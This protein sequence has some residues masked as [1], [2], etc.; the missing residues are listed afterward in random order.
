MLHWIVL[1]TSWNILSGYTGYFSFGHGAFFGA[2]LYTTSTLLARYDWP[3]L[4]TL[5]VAAAVA[6]VLGRGAR[7]GGLSRPE[8]ARRAVRAAHAGDHLRSR[9]DRRQHADRR[10]PGRVARRGSGAADR[11]DA[12][13]DLL[14]ARARRGDAHA[15]RRLGDLRLALRR[16]P[17]RD[18]RRRGR[19]RGDGRAD[20]PLQARCARDLVRA[21]RRGRR[22]PCAVPVVRDGRRGVHDH[23]A[24][25]GRADERAR[26]HAPLGRPG[27]RRGRDHR[28]ALQLHRRRPRGRRQGRDR[29]D[30]DRRDPVHA[31]RHPAAPAAARCG[32]ARQRARRS[33]RQRHRHRR[34]AA[35]DAQDATRETP[36][37]EVVCCACTG[38]H[39][40]FKGVRALAGV[41]VEVRRGE[42][43]GLL[44]PNGSG[45]STFINVV[46]GHYAPT[47]RRDRL[48]RP[49]ARAAAPRIASLPPASRARTR[50]RARL[51]T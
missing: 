26:R 9:H 10:R 38:L 13:V 19:R 3:F 23:G 15:A 27:D 4:W 1:A 45:K 32:A 5:P 8:R 22:H 14:P 2:G 46:S 29:R 7:R 18:P 47:A 51:R 43:L 12:I 39:K 17:V 28:P 34:A 31:R 25:D 20:L 30:P 6:A 21:R 40:R 16:G 37:G 42:I 36:A 33:T 24:A 49:R 11:P 41:D 48:R 35:R 50:S 44:G